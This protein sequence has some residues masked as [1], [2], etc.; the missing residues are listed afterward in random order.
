MDFASVSWW[1]YALAVLGGFGFGALQ[2]LLVKLAVLGKRKAR[3]LYAVK[4][5]VWAVALVGVGLISLPLLV[6]F[7]AAA[8]V[9]Q[10][11]GSALIYAKAKKEAR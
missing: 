7:T 2:S 4:M 5:T 9:A 10:M 1:A 6:V 8:S 11:V 3:W